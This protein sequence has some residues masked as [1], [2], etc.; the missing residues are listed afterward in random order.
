MKTIYIL[1]LIFIVNCKAQTPTISL[2]GHH[3]T[4]VEN[5]YYKDLNS[6][7]DRFTGSWL[8]SN[9]STSFKIVIDKK[10]MKYNTFSNIYEDLLIGEY[11]Y[12]EDGVVKVNT[13]DLMTNPPS[14]FYEHTS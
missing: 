3:T 8:Y 4:T 13:L 1:F 6:D 14:E 9:G 12:V 7:L 5:A 11:R 10:I 2:F